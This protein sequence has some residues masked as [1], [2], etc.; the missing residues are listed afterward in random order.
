MNLGRM[1]VRGER[2]ETPPKEQVAKGYESL[3]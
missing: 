2:V 1:I 3:R